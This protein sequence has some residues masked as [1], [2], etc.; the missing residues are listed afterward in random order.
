MANRVVGFLKANPISFR[1]GAPGAGL[2]ARFS[3]QVSEVQILTARQVS[4]MAESRAD[5]IRRGVA[6]EALIETME[7]ITQTAHGLSHTTP[8]LNARFGTARGLGDARLL[9]NARSLAET[10][11]PFA[12]RF[13]EF[14]LKSDFLEDLGAKIDTFAKAIDDHMGGKGE[15]V[16]T[17]KLIGTTMEQ[18]LTTLA[19]LDSIVANKLRGNAELLVK[20]EN[21]RKVERRWIYKAAGTVS[22]ESVAAR[23]PAA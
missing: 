20:W 10:V 23:K 9:T 3:S 2:V 6:R 8:G 15:H 17:V 18:A 12:P 13:V 19:Q 7:C 21:V 5:S 4:G 22:P 14:E 11:K 16:A 1:K